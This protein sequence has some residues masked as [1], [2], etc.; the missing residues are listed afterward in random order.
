MSPPLGLTIAGLT[1]TQLDNE[2]EIKAQVKLQFR[3]PKNEK[4]VVTRNLLLT[5]K[6]NTRSMKTLECNLLTIKDGERGSVSKIAA[7]IDQLIPFELGVSTAIL[8]NVIFCHQDESLWPLSEPAPLKKK[9][10]EIFEAMKYTK[11][12]DNIK[13]IRKERNKSMTLLK[14]REQRAKADKIKGDKVRRHAFSETNTLTMKQAEKESREL[15]AELKKLREEAN[16]LNQQAKEAEKKWKETS[17]QA[18]EFDRIVNTL[19][20]KKEKQGWLQKNVTSLSKGL[21]ERKESDEWLQ[22]ELDQFE[23]RLLA[24]QQ[25]QQ[26]QTAQYEQLC[27][28]ITE[29]GN[30]LSQLHVDAGKYEEQKANHEQQIENRKSMIREDSRSHQIRGFEGDLDDLQIKDY[31]EMIRKRCKDQNTAVEKARRGM[32]RE[33]QQAQE[34]LSRLGEHRTVLNESK[35]SSRQQISA[36]DSKVTGFQTDINKIEIDEGGIA[37]IEAN[38]EDLQS[39]LDKA[40]QEAQAA[41]WE[42]VMSEKNQQL[43]ALDE[44]SR[45]VN[46]DL[47]QGTKQAG[48]LARL[49]HIKKEIENRQRSLDTISAVNNDRLHALVDS[50]WQPSTVEAA[51]Q[52]KMEEKDR[53]LSIAERE[54]DQENRS[55]EHINFRLTNVSTDIKKGEQEL[56]RCEALIREKVRCE[57]DQYLETLADLQENRDVLKRDVDNFENQREYFLGAIKFAKD[58]H[59]C[60]LC[61][62]SFQGTK[63]QQAFLEKVEAKIRE[64]A[65]SETQNQL[66]EFEEDLRNAKAA[67]PS[68][69]SWMRITKVELPRLEEQ[70][71]EL[72][73]EKARALEGVER[74]DGIVDRH[75]EARSELDTLKKSVENIGKH[76]S[77]IVSLKQQLS[78]L[79]AKQKDMGL[80]RT[81][82]EIQE[83]LDST[84]EK[85]NAT[86]ST[87]TKL[88]TDKER[89]RSQTSTMELDLSKA[90]NS[91]ASANHQIEKKADF[92]RQIGDL[93]QSNVKHRETIQKLDGQLRDL[94]PKIAEEE[95]KR[96]DTKQRWLDK[97]AHL[98]E[99]AKRLSDSQNRLQHVEQGIRQYLDDGGPA[100]LA[101]AHRD[102]ESAQQ[103][104][105]RAEDERKQVT[106]TIN[107]IN[108]ELT[109]QDKSK[110]I[111]EDNI[112]YRQSLKELDGLNKEIKDLSAQNAEADQLHWTREARRWQGRYTEL[113]TERT[114][115]IAT[116]RAKDDQLTKLI[117]DWDTEYKGAAEAFKMAHIEVEV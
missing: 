18:A 20:V 6:K 42:K 53:N 93:R 99:D 32:E 113:S 101:K 63:E 81:L 55:L 2:R 46:K 114:S 11:A 91:L 25:H 66:D 104:I 69:D 70:R 78:E 77:D 58:K 45:Q 84:N 12:L 16:D 65:L 56:K 74:L 57:P 9:F 34:V 106:V 23:E 98:Q 1:Y 109:S 37:V 26:Q 107:K 38:M 36:N 100:K 40:K 79:A 117:A 73:A 110:R 90:R 41:S 30:K 39:R 64:E 51:F 27:R 10:D 15:D 82:D 48:D 103:E 31:L 24:H 47:I 3:T 21:E 68:N 19:G 88:M 54:R 116:A 29:G 33:M 35:N 89:S 87:I 67:G 5:V 76:H 8:E 59:K 112:K 49:D 22:A 108:K 96:D 92:A 94:A 86:R 50:K 17:T 13:E 14:E 44:E 4:M 28:S 97:E 71:K 60:K 61:T 83:Q 111:I 105:K 102:I 75:K 43:T 72:N 95:A 7:E 80:S 52:S 85:I 115:K 62:R